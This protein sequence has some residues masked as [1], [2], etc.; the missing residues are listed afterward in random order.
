M[1]EPPTQVPTDSVPVERPGIP[2]GKRDRNRRARVASLA[3]AALELFL[4]QGIEGTSIDDIT[5]KAGTAKGSFY[6]YFSGK[7]ALVEALIA[8]ISEGFAVAFSR[9]GEALSQARS[10]EEMTEAYTAIGAALS[11]TILGNPDLVRLYLQENRGAARGARAP[12]VALADR[13]RESA[14]AITTTAHAHGLLRA[15][16]AEISALV[17]I[18]ASER[19]VLATLNG[20][21]AHPERLPEQVTQLVLEG[22]AGDR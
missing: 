14:I 15:F 19:L 22:L 5:K 18:G 21:I 4:V 13:I 6:R 12:I 10:P 1:A 8:P 17:V 20:R 16:P 11:I 3:S 2:G 9:C 7:E